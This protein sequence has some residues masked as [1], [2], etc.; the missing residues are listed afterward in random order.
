M[1]SYTLNVVR[2]KGG[3]YILLRLGVRVKVNV[4]WV[5][6]LRRRDNVQCLEFKRGG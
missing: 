5:T 2:R 6:V 1:V 4:C 3:T